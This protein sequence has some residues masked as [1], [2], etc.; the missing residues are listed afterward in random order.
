M[1]WQL[2][3]GYSALQKLALASQGGRLWGGGDMG[4]VVPWG[5]PPPVTGHFL[6]SGE[7]RNGSGV[8]IQDTPDICHNHHNRWLCKNI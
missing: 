5:P 3:C 8:L 6:H 1:T 2:L 7:V 4:G